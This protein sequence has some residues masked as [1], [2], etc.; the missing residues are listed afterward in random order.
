MRSSSGALRVAR[1]LLIAAAAA[2]G[3]SNPPRAAEQSAPSGAVECSTGGVNAASDRGIAEE[4]R[5][6][7]ESGPA[8]RAL[9][10][11]SPP[12]SCT[13]T[14]R[15]GEIVLEYSFGNGGSL[16][17]TRDPRIEYSN[18]EVRFGSTPS[19]DVIPLLREVERASFSPDGCGI[20]WADATPIESTDGVSETGYYGETCNCQARVRADRASK[21]VGFVFRSTC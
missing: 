2:S 8:Y 9:A 13:A 4:M 3:C 14:N 15:S 19:A 16:V 12:R 20:D 18:Q 6:A 5:R 10:A 7:V 21:V 1:T 11:A 17:F